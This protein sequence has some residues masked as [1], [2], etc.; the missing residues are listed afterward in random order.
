M[1]NQQSLL[2]TVLETLRHDILYHHN[3]VFHLHPRKQSLHLR[4]HCRAFCTQ[5]SNKG[6]DCSDQAWP[7][8]VLRK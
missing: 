8:G 7:R 4:C 1:S 3:I 2:E 6:D 5:D